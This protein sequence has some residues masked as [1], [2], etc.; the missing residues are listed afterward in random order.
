MVDNFV[1]NFKC[2]HYN[3][4]LCNTHLTTLFFIFFFALV[5]LIGKAMSLGIWHRSVGW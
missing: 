1:M 4:A 5:G 3:I 2:K